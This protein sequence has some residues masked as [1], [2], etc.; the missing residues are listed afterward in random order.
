VL[1]RVRAGPEDRCAG[2]PGT[3][4]FTAGSGVEGSATR[5]AEGGL[6][7]AAL[8]AGSSAVRAA[9]APAISTTPGAR[10]RPRPDRALIRA[11]PTGRCGP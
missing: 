11:T 1:S 2:A 5:D 7:G 9:I 8:A 10:R 4:A 3:A 6:A